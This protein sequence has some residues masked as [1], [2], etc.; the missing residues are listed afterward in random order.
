[1]VPGLGLYQ[2]CM[3]TRLVGGPGQWGCCVWSWLRS[4]G[5]SGPDE[6]VCV[7]PKGVCQSEGIWS[8]CGG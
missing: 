1:M 2:L 5:F 7:R 6:L 3:E 8:T 4:T